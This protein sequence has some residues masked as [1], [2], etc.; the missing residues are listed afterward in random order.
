MPV[1]KINVSISF[2]GHGGIWVKIWRNYAPT[3]INILLHSDNYR[4]YAGK[5]IID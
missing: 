3:I 5:H 2:W 1:A 4:E